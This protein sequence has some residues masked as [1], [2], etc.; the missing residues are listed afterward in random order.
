MNGVHD[1]NC[2]QSTKRELRNGVFVKNA[3]T[4]YILKTNRTIYFDV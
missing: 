3:K 4:E 1:K 2:I